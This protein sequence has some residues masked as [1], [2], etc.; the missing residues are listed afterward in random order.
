MWKAERLK[1]LDHWMVR[2]K[3]KGETQRKSAF[4]GGGGMSRSIGGGELP[5]NMRRSYSE[6]SYRAVYMCYYIGSMNYFNTF[7]ISKI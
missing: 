3:H 5:D 4:T 7:S 1:Q 6:R 2:D